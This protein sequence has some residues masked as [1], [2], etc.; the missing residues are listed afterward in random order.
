MR[1]RTP[2]AAD[3]R[4]D[5]RE[6]DARGHVRQRVGEHERALEHRLRLDPVRDVDHLA[7]QARSRDH[8]VARADEVVVE[9]EVGQ[10]RDD[11]GVRLSLDG[12]RRGSPRPATRPR[13][14][15]AGPPTR[16]AEVVSGPIETTGIAGS[17]SAST[18]AAER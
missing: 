1:D 9:P 8:P 18:R 6:V 5:D 7:R 2:L 12:A 4:V 10:E 11:H 16:A 15:R 17:I 3:A 13:G 14:R